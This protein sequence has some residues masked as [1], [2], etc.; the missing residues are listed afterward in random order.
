MSISVLGCGKFSK[1]DRVLCQDILQLH[2]H[3]LSVYTL[4]GNIYICIAGASRQKITVH[5]GS[6][7]WG[8]FQGR[9]SA[10]STQDN[11]SS[12]TH[13]PFALYAVGQYTRLDFFGAIKKHLAYDTSSSTT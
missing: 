7:L 5:L 9:Q 13:N 10:L 3:S 11:L 8:I 12:L 2:M 6:V 1:E 4:L